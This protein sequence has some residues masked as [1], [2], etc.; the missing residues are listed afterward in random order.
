MKKMMKKQGFTLIE[1]MVVVIIVGILAAVAVPL[2]SANKEKAVGSEAIS[3]LGS[4]NT[5]CRLYYVGVGGNAA[6]TAALTGA[7][8]FNASDLQ[9]THFGQT[10]YSVL[11]IGEMDPDQPVHGI[12]AATASS[13]GG[14][15]F[16]FTWDNATRQYNVQ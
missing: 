5:A 15:T 13:K 10:G 9:G 11:T 8:Y 2:M 14:K 3:A 4:L 6:N 7:G 1:L 16:V 12:V